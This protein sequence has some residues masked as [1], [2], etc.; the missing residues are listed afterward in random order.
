MRFFRLK[1]NLK[2]VHVQICFVSKTNPEK[3]T[4]AYNAIVP[5]SKI[6]LPPCDSC[7]RYVQMVT[8]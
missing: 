2:V 1:T 6:S 5:Q 7:W 3:V 4:E 8:K